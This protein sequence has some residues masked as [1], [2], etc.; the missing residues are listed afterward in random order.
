L[1]NAGGGESRVS[2][3]IEKDRRGGEIGSL[4]LLEM[5]LPGS[6]IRLIRGYCAAFRNT[7]HLSLKTF[8]GGEATRSTEKKGGNKGGTG[9]HMKLFARTGKNPSAI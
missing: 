4:P 6:A 3:K 2:L 9:T 8:R 7:N 1:Q 5:S